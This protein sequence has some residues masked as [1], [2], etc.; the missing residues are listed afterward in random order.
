MP[1][2]TQAARV[3]EPKNRDRRPSLC[4]S[5]RSRITVNVTMPASTPT[6]NRS[7]R[8]PMTAQCPI[9]GIANVRENSA[10]YASMIVSSSTMKPQK[11]AACAAPGTDHFSSFRCPNTSVS[12]VFRSVAA[13]VLRVLEPLRGRLPAHR[14]PLQPPEPPPRHRERDNG[15]PQAD[16]HACNH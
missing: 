3:C 8:K 5:F 2:T 14:Q 16:D 1:R 15:Q 6:A 11:V 9:P 10:P 4:G 13:C 7:S 12:W